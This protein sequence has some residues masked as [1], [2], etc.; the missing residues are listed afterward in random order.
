V[1]AI[2]ALRYAGFIEENICLFNLS[3]VIMQKLLGFTLHELLISLV[4]LSGSSLLVFLQEGEF[5]HYFIDGERKIK[6]MY[7]NK[8]MQEINL[9]AIS[10]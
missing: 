6:E 9:S 3:E 1:N 5:I 8:T 2:I 7:L 4:L 10:A